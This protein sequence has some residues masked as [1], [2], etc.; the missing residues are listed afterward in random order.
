MSPL[1]K[2]L[3]NFRMRAIELKICYL[4]TPLICGDTNP[5][6]R[7]GIMGYVSNLYACVWHSRSLS[8]EARGLY[9]ATS[10]VTQDLGLCVTLVMRQSRG[11]GDLF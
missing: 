11:T 9:F 3:Q 4:T 2:G 7:M 10:A 8:R 6:D 1:S 5:L